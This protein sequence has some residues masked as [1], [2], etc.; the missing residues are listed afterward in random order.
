MSLLT[1]KLDSGAARKHPRIKESRTWYTDFHFVV[2]G[3]YLCPNVLF[4][5]ENLMKFS[6]P[7]PM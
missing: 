3:L 2:S 1:R 6:L 7:T 4:D 5:S